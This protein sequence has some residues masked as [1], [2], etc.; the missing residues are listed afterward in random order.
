M[1]RRGID[2]TANLF[3]ERRERPAYLVREIGVALDE[4][5]CPS[6]GEAEEVV[7]HEHLAIAFGPCADPDRRHRERLGD[8]RGDGNGDGFEHDRKAAGRFE[9]QS[10]GQELLRFRGRPALCLEPAE[11][12]LRLRC[13][14]DVPHH[15]DAGGDDRAHA[16]ERRPGTLEL[17]DVS[18]G[19]LD[20]PDRVADGVFVG[21][22][23]A[24]ER[25]VADDR[26][27]ARLLPTRSA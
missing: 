3:G 19:F 21:D 15:A 11:N 7:V 13:Q 24:P 27:V 4:A 23:I 26:A 14:A 5:R 10:V 22:V 6:L 20:E 16:R 8:A 9:R 17:D 2:A 18:A 1:L 25:H 12:R